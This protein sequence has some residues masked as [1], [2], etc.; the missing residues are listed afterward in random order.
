MCSPLGVPIAANTY[1]DSFRCRKANFKVT[2]AGTGSAV[3][4]PGPT[5]DK[6]NIYTFGT[7]YEHMY[8]DLKNK[9]ERLCALSLLACSSIFGLTSR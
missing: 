3:R 9:D 2:S 6:P 8:Q 7:P 1:C 5:A 4:L